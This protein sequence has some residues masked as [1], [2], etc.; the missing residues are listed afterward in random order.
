M[1]SDFLLGFDIPPIFDDE[2]I[3]KRSKKFNKLFNKRLK[4]LNNWNDD[5]NLLY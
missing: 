4:F 5:L 2:G 1:L 3:D